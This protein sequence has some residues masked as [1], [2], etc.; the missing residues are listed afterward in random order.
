V[1]IKIGVQQGSDQ[2]WFSKITK[3]IKTQVTH[4][5]SVLESKKMID[6]YYFLIHHKEGDSLNNYFDLVFS[7][8]EGVESIDFLN[9][10]PS[11]CLDPKHL[12]R[13]W[14]ESISGI[15]KTLLKNDEIEEAWKI[16]GKQ[17]EWIV[18]MIGIHKDAEIPIQQFVQFMHFYTNAMGLGHKSKLTVPPLVFSF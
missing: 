4:L 18:D 15:D 12:D 5:V 6:W 17:S 9:S 1:W 16:I 10:L 3:M 11:Y 14:G 2:E 13:P 8:E 7:L